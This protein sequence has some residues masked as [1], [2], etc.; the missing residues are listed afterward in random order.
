VAFLHYLVVLAID[1]PARALLIGPHATGQGSRY[2]LKSGS[3]CMVFLNFEGKTI[4]RVPLGQGVEVEA[5]LFFW[6]GAELAEGAQLYV[7]ESSGTLVGFCE[8]KRV[9]AGWNQG[10]EAPARATE[11]GISF[12]CI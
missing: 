1:A 9:I 4:L 11:P 8:V 6:M 5:Q 10:N 7:Q 2:V 3:E 12:A